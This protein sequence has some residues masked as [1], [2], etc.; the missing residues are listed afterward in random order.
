MTKAETSASGPVTYVQRGAPKYTAAMSIVGKA[1][2]TG[3]GEELV[4]NPQYFATT[5]GIL[6]IIQLVRNVSPTSIA[7]PVFIADP[8]NNSHGVHQ[9]S[10]DGELYL[11]SETNK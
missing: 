7:N 8:G 10:F 6:K 1:Q 11:T 4:L 3:I 9:S 2:T 5:P